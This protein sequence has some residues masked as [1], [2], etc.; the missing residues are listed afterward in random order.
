MRTAKLMVTVLT[1]AVSIAILG[2]CGA[3]E[4][5]STATTTGAAPGQQATSTPATGTT[6]PPTATPPSGTAAPTVTSPS[7]TAQPTDDTAAVNAAVDDVLVAIRQHDRDRLHDLSGDRLRDRTHDADREH[8]VNCLPEGASVQIVSRDVT[9][10]GDTA[11]VTVTFEVTTADG[12][13]Q[14]VERVW[15]FARQPD[16]T[17]RLA[18]LPECPFQS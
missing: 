14:T 15:T 2:A 7:G 3:S 6:A 10:T 4:A 12:A 16:G 17:W 11:T 5:T 1:I 9:I 18:E 13:T 8:V